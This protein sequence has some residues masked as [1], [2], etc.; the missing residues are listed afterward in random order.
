MYLPNKPPHKTTNAFSK[1]MGYKINA[2]IST[3][4]LHTSNKHFETEI[5][6]T[7]PFIIIPSTYLGITPKK[8]VQD[9]YGENYNINVCKC[10][11]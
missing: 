7:M 3:S 9:L 11:A 8:H 6:N 2:Q 4:F 1:V 5:K 10:N